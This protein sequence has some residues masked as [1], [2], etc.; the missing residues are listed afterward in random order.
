MRLHEAEAFY[1]DLVATAIAADIVSMSGENRILAY[2][3]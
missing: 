2:Y 3:G 1:L